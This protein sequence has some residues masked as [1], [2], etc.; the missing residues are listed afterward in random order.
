CGADRHDDH[1]VGVVGNAR[2]ADGG[3]GRAEERVGRSS[4]IAVAGSSAAQGDVV[5]VYDRVVV[6]QVQ[7]EG[8][9]AGACVRAG[10]HGHGVGGAAAAHA[11]DGRP[12]NPGLH[13]REVA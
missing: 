13:E 10:T 11:G 12:S 2:G 6:H 1:A 9:A 8:V 3:G 4:E 5:D 7:A